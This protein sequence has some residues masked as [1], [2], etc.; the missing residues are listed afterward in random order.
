[1]EL[2]GQN[3]ASARAGTRLG[4]GGDDEEGL[5]F[6]PCLEAESDT[7]GGAERIWSE[8]NALSGFIL[9]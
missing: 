9:I 2:G 7:C 8:H 1:M 5:A 3:R 4:A 6:L